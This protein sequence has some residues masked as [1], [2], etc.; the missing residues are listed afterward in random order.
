MKTTRK[1]VAEACRCGDLACSKIF[2]KSMMPK[3]IKRAPIINPQLMAKFF[4]IVCKTLFSSL[5][6]DPHV[7]DNISNITKS[8]KYRSWGS[9]KIMLLVFISWDL[10]EKKKSLCWMK[11]AFVKKGQPGTWQEV[12]RVLNLEYGANYLVYQNI[13]L[14]QGFETWSLVDFSK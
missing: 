8:A 3:N 11:M 5:W 2:L 6:G 7:M 4:M 1:N 12:Q 13:S 9:M 10:E 14:F